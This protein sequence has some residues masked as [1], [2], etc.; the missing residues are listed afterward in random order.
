MIVAEAEQADLSRTFAALA[1]PT[2]RAI[3][4]RLT[5]GEATVND[6][7]T[8]F[9]LTQQ[10]IS[11][12][13]QVLERAG[14]VSRG[15]AAQSRPCRLEPDRLDGAASWIAE[16]RRMWS[17]RYDRLDAHLAHLSRRDEANR[18]STNEP[19]TRPTGETTP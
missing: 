15:R 8:H 3:L 11:K 13:V 17:D 1:D 2:R 19:P 6:L 4:G 18:S 16:H 14:L 7:T 10:A 9:E 12:H 5:G